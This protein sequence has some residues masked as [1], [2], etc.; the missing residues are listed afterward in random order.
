MT[1]TGHAAVRRRSPSTSLGSGAGGRK[2]REASPE[3]QG[4]EVASAGSRVTGTPSTTS[5]VARPGCR[6]VATLTSWPRRASSAAS[7]RTWRSA[8]PMSGWNRSLLSRILMAPWSWSGRRGTRW[9]R[10]RRRDP[11]RRRAPSDRAPRRRHPRR[12]RAVR[13]PRAAPPRRA[14][15]GPRSPRWPHSTTTR[16][17]CRATTTPLRVTSSRYVCEWPSASATPTRT[18]RPLSSGLI[19]SAV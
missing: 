4:T 5:S 19:Q 10:R 12:A 13:P 11:G 2:R 17:S 3:N 16:S 18:S 14:A 6:V 9:E 7:S 1:S 8:P 15:A